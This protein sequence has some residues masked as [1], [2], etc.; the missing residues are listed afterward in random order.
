[1]LRTAAGGVSGEGKTIVAV[2][3]AGHRSG[4]MKYLQNPKTIPS[5]NS[6]IEIPK[7]RFGLAKIIGFGIVGLALAT[8]LLLLLSGTSPKLLFIAFGWWFLINGV[9]S[10]GG[11]LL[12]GGHPYS[13]LT[14]FFVAWLTS[15]NPMMAAGWFAGL[16][17]AKQRNPTTE[18]V[19]ALFG[20]ENVRDMLKNK[21]MRI[22]L[23]TSFANI[24]SVIGTFLGIHIMLKVTGLN[25]M[26]VL[27]A[28]FSAGFSALGL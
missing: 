22:L 17:E 2:I 28:G 12:A 7:K 16:M 26:E 27:N 8:F 19:K 18:D 14:A 3:G 25:P 21:F 6:L 20:I 11:T 5:L 9:L 24:G 4:V 15:L 23:V 10:A 13:I 1:L